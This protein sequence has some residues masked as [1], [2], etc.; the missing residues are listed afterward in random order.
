MEFRVRACVMDSTFCFR[1]QKEVKSEY[2]SGGMV[3][4]DMVEQIQTQS[5]LKITSRG[6]HL[7]LPDTIN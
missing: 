5:Y 4:C 7:R 3:Y 2:S 1:L 6:R